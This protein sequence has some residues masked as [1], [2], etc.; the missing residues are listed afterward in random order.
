M[1]KKNIRRRTR[2]VNRSLQ[3]RFLAMILIY[4][5]I[6]VLFLVLVLFV[7]D[8]VQM[9]DQSTSMDVRAAA[10]ERLLTKHVWVWPG[11]IVLIFLISIHSF[12]SFWRV[13]GPLY[14]FQVIFKQV[15]SGDL[16]YP[17]R[18]R[19]KDYLHPEAKTL[20]DMLQALA[21]KLGGIQHKGEDAL[22]SLMELENHAAGGS[23]GSDTHQ[24]L[25][26]A[27]RRHLEELVETARYF[28]VQRDRPAAAP[29]RENDDA[30]TH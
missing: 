7:P 2:V 1:V 4:S 25:L 5:A 8:I 12:R 14:R 10:A 27:H 24:A 3:Y 22:K 20:N 6:L 15:R 30:G 23:N 28:Q 29:D 9:G 13:V 21:E 19:S 26:D 11:A 16:S 18:I 17:I